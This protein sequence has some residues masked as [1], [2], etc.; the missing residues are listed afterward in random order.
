MTI[1]SHG[2]HTVVQAGRL[3]ELIM[4][5][6]SL[7][8]QLSTIKGEDMNNRLMSVKDKLL[9][10]T[11]P[12]VPNPVPQSNEKPL[13]VVSSPSQPSTKTSKP[14]TTTI[15]TVT[16]PPS[17]AAPTTSSSGALGMKTSSASL[18]KEDMDAFKADK[19]TLGKIP[20]CAPPPELC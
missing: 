15:S 16:K 5:R 1:R 11:G 13:M 10:T 7:I 8:S 19:F 9:S 20:T 3:Q 18:T 2:F 14:V 17:Q 6:K 4:K 12:V